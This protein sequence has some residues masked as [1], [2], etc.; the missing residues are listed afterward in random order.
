MIG[1]LE[2]HAMSSIHHHLEDCRRRNLSPGTIE[3]RGSTL[4]RCEQYIE[5]DLMSATTDELVEWLDGQD[6][7]AKTRYAYISHLSAFYQWLI[8]A[9]DAEHDPTVRIRRPKLRPNLP[10]PIATPDLAHALEQ[11]DPV[12]RAMLCLAAYA[13]ARCCEVANLMVD[14]V[15]DYMSPP[16][17]VLSGKGGK[18]RVVP[19]HPV[20]ADALRPVMPRHGS[21]FA[22]PAW[23]VSHRIGGHL[24]ACGSTA[25]AHQLRHW[26]ATSVYETSGGDLRM[27]QELLGHASP[28]TTAIYTAWSRSRAAGVVERLGV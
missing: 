1:W 2:T 27:V 24:D 13:G 15:L 28:A 18:Q 17:I 10:R 6:V 26:F 16:V 21:V 11:A 19:L 3:K 20:L 25:T 4:R 14:D 5:H 9:G 23:K 8:W 22:M 12:T 7:G